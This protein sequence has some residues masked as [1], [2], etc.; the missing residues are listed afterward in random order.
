MPFR[1]GR[2]VLELGKEVNTMF[3]ALVG[4][5]VVAVLEAGKPGWVFDFMD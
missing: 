4:N 1:Y 3:L 5:S 2:S